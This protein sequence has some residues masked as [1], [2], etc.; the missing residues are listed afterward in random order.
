MKSTSYD[1]TGDDVDDKVEPNTP[2]MPSKL[3]KFS[4]DEYS[5]MIAPIDSSCSES[6]EFLTM[7]QR[8][9]SSALHLH[10][11]HIDDITRPIVIY[12]DTHKFV[13]YQYSTL[14]K[15]ALDNKM[16]V[17]SHPEL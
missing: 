12:N 5:F 17:P 13:A 10:I 8:M 2:T 7:I 11:A 4:C 6:P 14:Q 9:V 16:M 15:F 1:S 3:F